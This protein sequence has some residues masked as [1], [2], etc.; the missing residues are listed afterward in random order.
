VRAVLVQIVAL[1]TA[2]VREHVE[3]EEAIAF[4]PR[5]KPPREA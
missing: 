4:A 5:P 2:V 3:G 1:Y